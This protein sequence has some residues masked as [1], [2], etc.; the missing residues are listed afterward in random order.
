MMTRAGGAT[1]MIARAIARVVVSHPVSLSDGGTSRVVLRYPINAARIARFS[2]TMITKVG[3][4]AGWHNGNRG[5]PDPLP[6]GGS[7]ESRDA[8]QSQQGGDK[9]RETDQLSPALPGL[10]PATGGP[11]LKGQGVQMMTHGLA[12]RAPT[13]AST[14]PSL[15]SRTCSFMNSGVKV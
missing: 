12:A 1:R 13:M 14:G 15:S 10:M 4:S 5:T 8:T 2:T 7:F 9:T 11:V 3:V 6:R